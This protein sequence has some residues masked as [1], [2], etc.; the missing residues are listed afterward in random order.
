MGIYLVN[1]G[2]RE[3]FGEEEDGWGDV[4]AALNEEL[5]R[6]GLP[7]Y[8]GV[9]EETDFARGSGTAFEEKLVPPMDGFVALCRAYLSKAEEELLLG[10]TVL[11][12]VP[13]DEE[14]ELPIESAYDLTTTVAGA[15]RIL[16]LTE[17]LATALE[18]PTDALPATS[19]N[20]E[21]TSWFLDGEA[22]RTAV[23]RPGRW[24][25]DLDTAFYTAVYLRAAQHSVR[26]G[27]PI[28]YS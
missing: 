13:L 10:W 25:D 28:V 1:V 24:A 15:P 20:L 18:L 5:G 22:K 7:P 4:A 2:A 14:I 12:P 27:C 26:R 3:W 21:L 11:V 16:A 23:A 8:T 9:P 6:R 19:D 17:R